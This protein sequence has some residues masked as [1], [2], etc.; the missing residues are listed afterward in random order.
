MSDTKK[1]M[2]INRKAPYGTVYAL[3]TQPRSIEL[4]RT[5]LESLVPA[6]YGRLG[7]AELERRIEWMRQWLEVKD[8]GE[9]D[10]GVV[11]RFREQFQATRIYVLTP[12]G[13]LVSGISLT[14]NFAMLIPGLAQLQI[15][16]EQVDRFP[17]LF[18]GH[19][20][21]HVRCGPPHQRSVVGI[22]RPLGL[23]VRL[24]L[25]DGVQQHDG[26]VDHDSRE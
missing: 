22:Y 18:P 10:E 25:P 7:D 9:D 4:L 1:F 15:I 26:V 3:D 8:D 12:R 24:V 13:E 21:I 23:V 2:Y 20:L 14:E 5:R 17:A 6:G 19:D 16:Q 11:E